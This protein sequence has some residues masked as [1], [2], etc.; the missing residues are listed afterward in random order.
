MGVAGRKGVDD[1]VFAGARAEEEDTA[2]G[3]ALQQLLQHLF[4]QGHGIGLAT[5]GG[6]GGHAYPLLER[7]LLAD[8][9]RQLP[10]AG[11]LGLEQR[12]ELGAHRIA[13]LPEHARIAL[14]GRG[15]RLQHLVMR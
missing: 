12:G 6:K 1:F 13:Q 4:H 5:M 2:R 7:T 8:D 10:Q 11:L 9:G 15:Q 14:E 3:V